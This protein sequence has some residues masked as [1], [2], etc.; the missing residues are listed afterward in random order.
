MLGIR[1]QSDL[2]RTFAIAHRRTLS[3]TY[4]AGGRVRNISRIL[5]VWVGA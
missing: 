5:P 3:D 1:K 4:P 2:A